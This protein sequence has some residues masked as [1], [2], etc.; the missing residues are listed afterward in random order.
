MTLFFLMT[1]IGPCE[2]DKPC[3]EQQR[4]IACEYDK[5]VKKSQSA[6]KNMFQLRQAFSLA[7]KMGA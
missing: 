5:N 2:H 1:I 4:C 6:R 3:R 7:Q